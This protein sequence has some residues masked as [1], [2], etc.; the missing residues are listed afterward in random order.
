MNIHGE[1]RCFICGHTIKWTA[2]IKDAASEAYAYSRDLAEAIA[3]GTIT[4]T[5]GPKTQFDIIAICPQCH[6]K[7]LFRSVG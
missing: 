3:T 1:N 2:H 7:N 5:E 4:A 6:N